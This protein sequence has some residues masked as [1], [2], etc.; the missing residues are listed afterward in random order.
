MD[1]DIKEN[2][3]KETCFY[4][5]IAQFLL[6][7]PITPV[8]IINGDGNKI[9]ILFKHKGNYEAYS[10][11]KEPEKCNTCALRFWESHSISDSVGSIWNCLKD[12]NPQYINYDHYKRLGEFA[13]SICND[14]I[15]EII[16]I[17]SDT[18][19]NYFYTMGGYYHITRPIYAK[20]INKCSSLDE[21]LI[22]NI[23]TRYI[24]SG[25]FDEF[26]IQLLK[27]EEQYLTL[28]RD[29]LLKIPVS[30]TNLIDIINWCL[31]IL[32]NYVSYSKKWENFTQKEKIIFALQHMINSKHIPSF[33]M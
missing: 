4:E 18:L 29:C 30:M 2:F 17:K 7:R 11:M 15:T 28:M 26:F 31:L 33:M 16:I 14:D 13:D 9:S 25:I 10:M 3:S 12:V 19:F 21:C 5:N 1:I 27:H 6:L 20:Y 24:I 32:K 23:F 8:E 22:K